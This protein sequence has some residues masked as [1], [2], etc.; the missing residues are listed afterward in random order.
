[1][2][3]DGSGVVTAGLLDGRHRSNR[4]S[5]VPRGE[6]GPCDVARPS[7]RLL[8]ACVKHACTLFDHRSRWRERTVTQVA[9]H[10]FPS[11]RE[12]FFA[13][14]AERGGRHRG[15]SSWRAAAGAPD[16][17]GTSCDEASGEPG[18]T[19]GGFRLRSTSFLTS[20]RGAIPRCEAPAPPSPNSSPHP[21]SRD[22]GGHHDLTLQR[23]GV[24]RTQQGHDMDL[25]IVGW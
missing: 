18:K 14:D 22:A 12:P 2:T 23:C 17:A 19:V 8:P 6:H 7:I 4:K 24:P 11:L 25:R 3:E 16:V 5:A 13:P 21:E 15:A 1:L 10:R 9:G 20:G